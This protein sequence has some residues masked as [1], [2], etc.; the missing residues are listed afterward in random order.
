MEEKKEK[1]ETSSRVF[2][3]RALLIGMLLVP[4]NVYWIVLSE[5]R[6][7]N[8]LTGNPLFVTPIFFLFVM[9]GINRMLNRFAPKLVLQPAEFVIIYVMLVISC[10]I[11]AQEYMGNLM[12]TIPWPRWFATTQNG[13]EKNMFP[14]LPHW[15]FVWDKKLLEG[16][17]QGNGSVWD[18]GVL[19]MWL[20]PMAFWS[21]FILTSGWIMFCLNVIL[22]KAWMDNT[23]L[24]YPMVRLP[25]AMMEKNTPTSLMNSPVLWLGFILAGSVCFLG[26]L[27][28]WFPSVNSINLRLTTFDFSSP[29]WS[30]IGQIGI[31]F[32][33]FVIGLAFLVPLDVSFSCWFFYLFYKF[34]QFIG[35][36]W[37]LA[38]VAGFPFRDEQAMG[39]WF[40]FSLI[41]VYTSRKY[42]KQVFLIAFKNRD[43]SD[44]EEPISYRAA[45]LGAVIGSIIVTIFWVA[46]G[47][48]I[49]W[50]L[51]TNAI[52]FLVSIV[53][54]R[55][56][57]EAGA[58][59]TMR[60]LDPGNVAHLF[61]S[62]MFGPAALAATASNHWIWR[63]NRSNMMPNHMEAFKIA[64]E[65]GMNLR[66]LVVPMVIALV[67]A[68]AAGFG[69]MLHVIYK[70]GAMAG[71][72]PTF[73][74][75]AGG[76]AF[77]NWLS[78]A[79]SNGFQPDAT[80]WGV[81][82]FSAGF[83]IFLSWLR[84]CYSWFPFHPLGFCLSFGMG[85]HWVPFLIA[86]ICKFSILRIGGLNLYRQ[87]MPF[88]LGLILGDYVMGAFWSL[89][90][91][92][93]HLPAYQIFP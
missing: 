48:G 93:Y 46:A 38:S 26:Q 24:S 43:G 47:M 27:H 6:W 30:A 45:F 2:Y 91:V 70:E 20:T 42:L 67:L 59:H 12:A 86:W 35:G 77:H 85:W 18:P 4:F 49:A 71:C 50:A 21:I 9:M 75:H 62:S 78:G 54:T 81:T 89:I 7:G 65:Q 73:P 8:L 58:Q 19:R 79:L 72:E 37:G 1:V 82:I 64:K 66:S 84:E 57:A 51:V 90:G 11:A 5:I 3:G 25:L 88:F 31:S 80:R 14:H 17:F 16:F 60:F 36:Q 23:K 33:P 56:R 39:S 83:V 74:K 28:L 32:Y 40:M 34:E 13:W 68:T 53:I 29:P 44:S 22:R 92:I 87:V 76:E 63:D 10:A 41:L 52:F 55:V 61:N 15:M 69:S